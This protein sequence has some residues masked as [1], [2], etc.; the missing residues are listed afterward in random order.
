MSDI[1]NMIGK[2]VEVIANGTRY[3]GVLIEVSDV[4]V[5]IRTSMQWISL[6]ASSVGEVR[7][8]G[9]VKR[10]PGREGLLPG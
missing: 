1:L 10:E 7:L 8:A 5:Q 6:P 2:E 9:E 3:R 4:E